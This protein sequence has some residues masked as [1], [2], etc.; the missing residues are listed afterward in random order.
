M[1]LKILNDSEFKNMQ[2]YNGVMVENPAGKG[3]CYGKC[4]GLSRMAW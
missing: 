2:K 1:N 3:Y 4:N